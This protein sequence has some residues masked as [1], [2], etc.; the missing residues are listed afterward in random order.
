MVDCIV[1]DFGRSGVDRVVGIVA[2]GVYS[3]FAG[4]SAITVSGC[5]GRRATEGIQ[6]AVNETSDRVKPVAVLIDRVVRD[7]GCAWVD[8]VV[9]IVA[10]GVYSRFARI[11]AVTV[12]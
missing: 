9:G 11:Q 7:F 12:S 5:C 10:V 8:R 3:R 6:V 4:V 2:V 1:W